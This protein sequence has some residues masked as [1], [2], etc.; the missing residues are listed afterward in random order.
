MRFGRYRGVLIF[1]NVN[2]VSSAF[3]ICYDGPSIYGWAYQV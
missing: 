1:N 2:G 3:F